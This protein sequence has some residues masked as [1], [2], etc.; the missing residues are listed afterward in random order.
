MAEWRNCSVC[1]GKYEYSWKYMGDTCKNFECRYQHEEKERERKE[2][3]GKNN[4]QYFMMQAETARALGNINDYHH[5]KAKAVKIELEAKLAE[6]EEKKRKEQERIRLKEL[7]LR[8]QQEI[9]EKLNEKLKYQFYHRECEECAE[10]IK[11]KAK[12]CK[13]CSSP[14]PDWKEQR[15]MMSSLEKQAEELG[16]FPWNIDETIK[17]KEREVEEAKQRAIEEEEAKKAAEIQKIRDE[18]LEDYII[19]KG[20]THLDN[21]SETQFK[22]LVLQYKEGKLTEENRK[23]HGLLTLKEKVPD[24]TWS[25]FEILCI[26]VVLIFLAFFLG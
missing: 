12:I 23:K 19:S 1:G 8:E 15:A 18:E 16:C 9:Q 11:R 2:K 7:E 5:F 25:I 10:M 20:F 21:V 3:A 14:I 17:R 6:V 24:K 4:S 22:K 26:F 13:E